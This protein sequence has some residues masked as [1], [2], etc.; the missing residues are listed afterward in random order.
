MLRTYINNVF[1]FVED[2]FSFFN[3][4]AVMLYFHVLGGIDRLFVGH[5]QR[6]EAFV[7]IFAKRMAYPV[8]TQEQAAHV[9]VSHKTDAEVIIHFTLVEFCAFPNIA[10]CRQFS[11]LAVGSDSF[12]Y[13]VL[14]GSCLFQMVDYSQSFFSPVHSGE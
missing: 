6:V 4:A 7:I 11:F 14:A 10:D 2:G 3:Y 1:I 12:N 8:F 9:G 13:F 5:P